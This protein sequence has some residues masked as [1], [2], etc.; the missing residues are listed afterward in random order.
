MQNHSKIESF[1]SS[2]SFS[3]QEL[4][5]HL[6]IGVIFF[7][8][9]WKIQSVNKNFINF[10]ENDWNDIKLE[11]INLFSQN[12]LSEKLPL[13][14]VLL[15]REGK[16]FEKIIS[17]RNKDD[18][19]F[20]LVLKGSPIFKDGVF[21]GGTLVLED[22]NSHL[23]QIPFPVY[24]SNS[25]MSF[26]NKICKCYIALSLEGIV[27]YISDCNHKKMK[28]A[29]EDYANKKLD[30]IFVFDSEFNF[31]KF[32]SKIKNGAITETTALSYFSENEKLSYNSVFLPLVNEEND[33]TS[34]IVLLREENFTNEDSIKFLTDSSSLK[35]Y[36]TFSKANANGLFKINLYGNVTYWEKNAEELLKISEAEIMA[37]SIQK[38]FPDITKSFFERIRKE[39]LEN[40]FWEGFLSSKNKYD[41]DE[42]LKVKIIPNKL[43][44][45][46]NFFVYCNKIDKKAKK[47]ISIKEEEK[48]FFKDTVVKSNQMILKIN[49][50][51]IIQFVNEKFCDKYEYN[52]DEVQ[53]KYFTDF[54]DSEFIRRYEI[55]DFDILITKDN[56]QIFPLVSKSGIIKEVCFSINVS[57]IKNEPNYFT[58]YLKECNLKD[59]L[60]LE[61]THSL[62]YQ[63]QD[64][65]FMVYEGQIIKVNPKFCELF[66]TEF[67]TDY[68]NIN[69]LKIVD[70]LSKSKFEA[71]LKQNKI[72]NIAK[73]LTFVRKN[74]SL[75][76]AWINKI[77]CST[78]SDF[79][80]FTIKPKYE[81]ANIRLDLTEKIK[82]EFRK[83]GPFFWKSSNYK[84]PLA[85][86]YIS[87]EFIKSI[88]F[89][90]AKSSD[91]KNILKEIIHP[92][93]IDMVQ[94]EIE[95]IVS[96]KNENPSDVIYRIF[97][98]NGE[99]VW[100][101]NKIKRVLNEDKKISFYGEISEVTKLVLEKEELRNKVSEL[102]KLNTAKEK[103][104]SI[105]SHDLKSPFTS[106]VGFSE[107]MLTDSTL[108][109]EE[110][111]DYVGH[112]KD[113]SLH[114]IDLLNG[115]LDL[116]KLQTGRIEVE[117]RIVNANLLVNKT[118]EILSGL[119]FQK[120]ISLSS[121][122]DKSTYINVDDNLVFQVFNNLVANSIKFTPKGGKISISARKIPEQQKVE[123]TVKDTGVGIEPDDIEKLFVIDKKFTTLGT[124]GERGTGLGLSLVKEII[125][126]HNS[127]IYVNS[128]LGEGTEFIFT[129]P[130]SSP[131]VLL[132]DGIESELVIYSR[133][134][135]SITEDVT[136]FRAKNEKDALKIIEN[137]MP[138]L[139]I[140]EHDLP[141][142]KGNEFLQEIKKLNLLYHPSFMVLSKNYNKE[143]NS[144][145]R[146]LGIEDVFSK[147]F[148]LK[149]FKSRL[150]VLIERA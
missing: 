62:L 52:L 128:K 136:I 7:S 55:T 129:L 95:K 148:I 74:G 135:K 23:Q 63:F 144:F 43:Q 133:L 26:L 82:K 42:I 110:I 57:S 21:K 89:L 126:K 51:G 76:E 87:A 101:N 37:H 60:L 28:F 65:V 36:E 108:E 139:I 64:P 99:V 115:L 58:F 49:K 31:E 70:L 80:V 149:E 125:D 45:A 66:G 18:Q 90:D 150:D 114:T 32:L 1:F 2:L 78:S 79:S 67:E 145:Y 116:T 40:N 141:A 5:E 106:I 69:A 118:V 39:I 50:H 123:F 96:G 77:S 138:M 29:A 73:E 75:F 84:D 93:D 147:P 10:F 143:L 13:T 120:E 11:G 30:E 56:N 27:E 85:A 48:A 88:G 41:D 127:K 131:S 24:S 81:Y 6:P 122:V 130:I 68:F 104:I 12:I 92:N 102:H 71:L 109:K 15:L 33:V 20:D 4:I 38:I 47:I 134:L 107:L 132:V 59:K 121:T 146:D 72:D 53:G 137:K 16:H 91:Q 112:I 98:K 22:Y 19:I 103:F 100:I 105:I 54:I 97:N 142:M 25:L 46:T 34:I 140:F 111:L 94:D 83:F 3:W 61:T 14:D 113:A 17:F 8:E 44:N 86:D 35:E 9:N 117:P 124:A 119:A